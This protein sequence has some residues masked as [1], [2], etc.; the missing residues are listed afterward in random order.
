M[1]TGACD[2]GCL[3]LLAGSGH[4]AAERMPTNGRNLVRGADP[5]GR[6]AD[7]ELADQ[8]GFGQVRR[9]K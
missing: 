8:A 5:G 2:K 4:R 7:P 9:R 6:S 1:S 3:L